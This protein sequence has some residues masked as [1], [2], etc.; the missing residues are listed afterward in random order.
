MNERRRQAKDL[1][2]TMVI[3]HAVVAAESGQIV[4]ILMDDGPGAQI[5]T[6]EINRLQRLR[7]SGQ[8]VGSVVLASTLTVLGR[9]A[10]TEYLPDRSAM[11]DTY[12]RLR[13]LTEQPVAGRFDRR[14]TLEPV[15]AH[16][17]QEAGGKCSNGI[18]SNPVSANHARICSVRSAGRQCRVQ[19]TVAPARHKTG[20]AWTVRWL[21]RSLTLPENAAQQRHVRW[22]Y[23]GEVRHQARVGLTYLE[24]GQAAVRSG[25]AGQINVLRIGFDQAQCGHHRGEDDPARR[26]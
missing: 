13:G 15:D 1:G 12:T 20:A 4:T 3:A 22:Q 21:S 11:R 7:S 26:R 17:G 24:P 18:S 8:P 10:S 16:A 23:V 19:I 5:A 14:G 6:L 25:L 2:E 9:A